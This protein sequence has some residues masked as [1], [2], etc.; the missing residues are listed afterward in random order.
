MKIIN[1]LFIGCLLL[2]SIFLASCSSCSN[3]NGKGENRAN[4]TD[5]VP[6]FCKADTTQVLKM[7]EDY[8]EALKNQKYDEALSK[9]NLI[10]NDSVKP[11]PEKDKQTIIRQQQ[12]FPVLDYHLESFKF[13]NEHRVEVTY[14][15][16][17]FKKENPKDPIQNTIRITFAPQR[18]NAQWYLALMDKS[19]VTYVTE[20]HEDMETID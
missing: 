6:T 12:V 1:K 10:L 15:I 14:S 9:L 20:K 2:G 7:A 11:L 4:T 16:E 13:I 8:L 3:G 5:T 17:F 18:I 19:Y